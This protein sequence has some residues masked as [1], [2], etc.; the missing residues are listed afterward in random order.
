MLKLFYAPGACSMASHIALEEAGASYERVRVNLAGGEQRSEAYAK[1]N[2]KGRVP[3]LATDQGILTETTAI[4]AYIAQT[5]PKAKLA[6]L[7]DPFAFARVQ[8]FNAY[9]SSTVHVSHAHRVRGSRWSD[10]PAIIEG[11]KPKVAQNMTEAFQLIETKMLAG[12]YVLGDRFTVA[13]GYLFTMARWLEGDG[14]DIKK[15][16]KVNDHQKRVADRPAVQRILAAEKA[17]A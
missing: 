16:P 10:D 3:V 12:P 1:I 9:L 11:M 4:L 7:D 6:P 2:P 8:E 15:F 5:H 13:D 14:V 17:A